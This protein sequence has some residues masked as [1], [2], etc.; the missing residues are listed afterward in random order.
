MS[1]EQGLLAEIFAHPDDDTPRLVYA[2]WLD[3]HGDESA[4]ARADLIRVQID[5]SRLEEKHPRRREVAERERELLDGWE[6]EWTRPLRRYFKRME[7][8]RGFVE[9]V[10]VTA[11]R[12]L[13]EGANLFA[14]APLRQVTLVEAS[15]QVAALVECPALARLECL[16]LN[17]DSF[18]YHIEHAMIP[19]LKSP[20]LKGLRGLALEGLAVWESAAEAIVSALAEMPGLICLSLDGV[21]GQTYRMLPRMATSPLLGRLL[22]LSLVRGRFHG[23]DVRGLIPPSHPSPLQVLDLSDNP[24]RSPAVVEPILTSP[25]FPALR[26]VRLRDVLWDTWQ[27]AEQ[28]QEKFGARVQL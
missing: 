2:D 20:H 10:T 25:N 7:F 27:A 18:S 28:L 11:S 17:D 3:E 21:G 4:Q 15:K 16:G 12:F 26:L 6:L 19:F 8:R 1:A 14:I 23:E 24:L 9:R 22:E 13:R 5:L